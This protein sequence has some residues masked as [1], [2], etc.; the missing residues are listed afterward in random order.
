M[1]E[2]KA[3]FSGLAITIQVDDECIFVP[4]EHA[5]VGAEG[6]FVRVRQLGAR[7]PVVVHV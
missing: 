7:T 1:A 2:Q 6:I 3:E 4:G 5:I